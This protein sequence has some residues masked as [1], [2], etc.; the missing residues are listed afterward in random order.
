VAQTGNRLMFRRIILILGILLLTGVSI[1]PAIDAYNKSRNSQTNNPNN[2]NQQLSAAEQIAKLKDEVKVSERIL[3]RKPDDEAAL[4]DLLKAHLQLYRLK[5]GDIKDIIQTL[6]KL[7]KLKPDNTKYAV[8]L[9]QVKQETGDNEGAAQ[10]LRAVLETKPGDMAALQAM[11]AL[12]MNQKRPEAAIGL[13]QDALAKAAQ[14]NK[15]QPGSI[16]TIAIQ[17]LIGNIHANQKRYGK[18]FE[19]Y[20]QAIK[21]A[22]NDY[23]PIWAKALVLKEQGKTEEAKP[24]FAKA[25]EKAPAKYKDEINKTATET[26]TP[27]PAPTPTPT[28]S[29][30]P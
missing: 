12:Q 26:T 10:T 27:S 6:E 14:A 13:L 7:V 30:T 8:L 11:V 17:V 20:E 4:V 1:V 2:N 5:Q 28:E 21:S 15:I 24:L 3:Q 25:L 29:P 16:D 19:L 23:R 9:A 22:P 18:A